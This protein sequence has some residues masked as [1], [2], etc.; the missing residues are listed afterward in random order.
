MNNLKDRYVMSQNA[1][2]ALKIILIAT[3]AV[4]LII[5][6]VFSWI[7]TYWHCVDIVYNIQNDAEVA[8][9]CSIMVFVHKEYAT[10]FESGEMTIEDFGHKNFKKM[11]LIKDN[12]YCVYLKEYG[13]RRVKEAMVHCASLDFVQA[14]YFYGTMFD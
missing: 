4:L 9:D 14:I 3:L 10:K 2:N 7:E 12:Y 1:K 11:E 5:G 13:V 8:S 6:L